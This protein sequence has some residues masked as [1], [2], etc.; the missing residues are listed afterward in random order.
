M[1][2]S[3]VQA[4][5]KF[6]NNYLNKESNLKILDIGSYD[7]SGTN[8]NYGR[9]LKEKNWQYQG[10][11]IQEGPN[12]DIVVS[13]IYNWVEIEDESYD[14][15]ISGQAFEHMEF[16]WEAIKEVKRILRPGGFCCI[17]APSEGPVHK[18]PFDC[19]RFKDNG[20]KAI[21]NYVGLEVIEYYTNNT[22]IS[23]PWY[24]SVLI[25]KKPYIIKDTSLDKR[26][27]IL[28]KKLELIL[29][30]INK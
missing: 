26:M 28:E 11:D 13:D 22:E 19:F 6:K 7:S 12:V 9:F 4:M 5:E 1:H 8:Y 14:V 15:V 18:N 29:K 17:I 30:K 21:A 23:N 25:A 24:D 20:M 3:S 16:F 2:K 10:M 27:S